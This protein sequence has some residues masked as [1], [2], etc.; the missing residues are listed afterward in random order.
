MFLCILCTDVI[1]EW[2]MCNVEVEPRVMCASVVTDIYR[3][4]LAEL[5]QNNSCASGFRPSLRRHLCLK[6]FIGPSLKNILHITINTQSINSNTHL[7]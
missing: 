4:F 7:K 1:N 5:G 3:L 6:I 2:I